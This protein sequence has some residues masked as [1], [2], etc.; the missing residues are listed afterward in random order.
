MELAVV[1]LFLLT[2]MSS[3][4]FVYVTFSKYE[5]YTLHKGLCLIYVICNCLRTVHPTRMGYMSNT[6]DVL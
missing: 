6:A 3:V 1:K 2:G 5:L 4:K